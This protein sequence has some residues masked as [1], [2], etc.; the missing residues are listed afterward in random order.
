MI[1]LKGFFLTAFLALS[2]FFL[3]SIDGQHRCTKNNYYCPNTTLN[4]DLTNQVELREAQRQFTRYVLSS[5]M[6]NEL[7]SNEGRKFVAE[8]LKR[9]N[10]DSPRE[11]FAY[12]MFSFRSLIFLINRDDYPSV[13]NYAGVAY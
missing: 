11:L 8:I 2:L 4:Y 7:L 3:Q 1:S 13:C 12:Y 5:Q 9:I 6:F 10:T